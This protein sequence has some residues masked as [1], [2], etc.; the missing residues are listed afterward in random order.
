MNPGEKEGKD[1]P[2]TDTRKQ[3]NGSNSCSATPK[4]RVSVKKK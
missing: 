4:K 2:D 3:L 1:H